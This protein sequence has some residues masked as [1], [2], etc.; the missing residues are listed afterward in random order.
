MILIGWLIAENI[1][2]NGS[3]NAATSYYRWQNANGDWQFS[4][5]APVKSN[6]EMNIS[7]VFGQNVNIS[8]PANTTISPTR[9]K[10]KRQPVSKP[11][12]SKQTARIRKQK[13][14]QEQACQTLKAKLDAIHKKLRSGYKEPKG[15]K[16]RAQRRKINNKI[17]K[18]C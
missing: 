18:Q 1:L 6:S 17:H 11:Q 10:L 5:Q 8:K 12:K 4:D 2:L 13:A 7:K 9:I 15:N 14:K 16:L 3:A